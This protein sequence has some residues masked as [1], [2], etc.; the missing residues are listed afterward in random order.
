VSK[1]L[2]DLAERATKIVKEQIRADINEDE[3][4]GIFYQ[5][6]CEPAVVEQQY[7]IKYKWMLDN[8]FKE[9]YCSGRKGCVLSYNDEYSWT[10]DDILT[11]PLK[12]IRIFKKWYDGDI[13]EDE[14]LEKL[15]K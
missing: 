6:F 8:G 14:L 4:T 15:S 9:D 5:E 7:E 12:N 3:I 10:Y 13:S 1:D 2:W 11:E